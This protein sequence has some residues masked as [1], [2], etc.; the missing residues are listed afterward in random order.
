MNL[1]LSEEEHRTLMSWRDF[2]FRMFNMCF[3]PIEWLQMFVQ[4]PIEFRQNL[5]NTVICM[6]DQI[7]FWIKITS[8]R[9]LFAEWEL[10]AKQSKK[11]RN[12]LSNLV[13]DL[14]KCT[15]SQRL[16]APVEDDND[17]LNQ[18]RAADSEGDKYRITL[19]VQQDCYH[20][21]DAE[22]EPVCKHAVPLLILVGTHARLSNIDCDGNFIHDEAFEYK[23]K[24]V[25]R[26]AGTSA[27]NL[28]RAWRELRD[29]SLETAAMIG[30]LDVMQQPAGFSDSIIAV[31]RLEVQQK[32]YPQTL[33]VRD[34]NASYLSS[35]ARK[36]SYLSHQVPGWIGGKMTAVLQVTDTDVARPL[37]VAAN[38]EKMKLRR[39]MS[40]LARRHGTRATFKCGAYEQ[41]RIVCAALEKLEEANAASSTLL[42]AMRRNGYLALRP[43]LKQKCLVRVDDDPRQKWAVKFPQ[44]SHRLMDAWVK[45]RYDGLDNHGVPLEPDWDGSGA[46]VKTLDDMHDP[47]QHGPEGT[48]VKLKCVAQPIEEVSVAI[49]CDADWSTSAGVAA[50]ASAAVEKLVRE[51]TARNISV[52]KLLTI[53]VEAKATMKQKQRRAKMNEALKV[54]LPRWRKQVAK[55]SLG[56]SRA[57]LLHALIP[58]AG[59]TKVKETLMQEADKVRN[60]D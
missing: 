54:L 47:T 50:V 15:T 11:T 8:T 59:V 24:P 28:L 55:A 51:R 12:P 2:D 41:L 14:A 31:W 4:N 30:R 49:D 34:L 57:Q 9:Q 1:S 37:K 45:Q 6:S 25:L 19:E 18:T 32:R 53:P 36:A 5:K 17:G 16:E 46:G 33:H 39:E 13:P 21:F 20:W 56:S 38:Q 23:G 48:E 10:V 7:P 52:D 29:S 27:R 22:V 43:D 35:D 3:G 58:C 44:G 40:E 26:K 60:D 42:A